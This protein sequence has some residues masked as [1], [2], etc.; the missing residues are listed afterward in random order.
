M[1]NHP[2]GDGMSVRQR[3]L[4]LLSDGMPHSKDEIRACLYD[5]LGS[6]S[7]IKC[8]ISHIRT[9]L[10][11]KGEDILIQFISNRIYYRHVRLLASPYDGHK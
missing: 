2:S 11:R 3:I 4:V 10:R 9:G 6:D 1:A 5:E 7:T 8:H